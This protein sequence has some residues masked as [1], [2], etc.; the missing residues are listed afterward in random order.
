MRISILH[1]VLLTVFAVVLTSIGTI[2]WSLD[3]DGFAALEARFDLS[4]AILTAVI[5]ILMAII[6]MRG[7]N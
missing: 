6:P 3:S 7:G 2:F 4:D 1:Y 5:F